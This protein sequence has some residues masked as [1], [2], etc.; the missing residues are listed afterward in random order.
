MKNILILLFI[1]IAIN[2]FAQMQEGDRSLGLQVTILKSKQI[3]IGFILPSFGVAVSD[4]VEFY[5]DLPIT[6]MGIEMT[7]ISTSTV[8][9]S[10]TI[11]GY[12]Y[13]YDSLVIK[14]E[15]KTEIHTG[16]LFD[17]GG[18]YYFTVNHSTV[19]HYGKFTT[20]WI[21]LGFFY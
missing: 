21:C 12:T 8:R 13:Y 10:R 14:S 4:N 3:T 11:G 6:I 17:L 2:S 15:T 16:I 5:F 20:T 18:N 9:K 19:G 1:L 7:N